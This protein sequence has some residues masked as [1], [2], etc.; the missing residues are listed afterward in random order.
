MSSPIDTSAGVESVDATHYRRTVAI[1]EHRGFIGVS[2]AKSGTALDV[3]IAPS[4]APVIGAVIVRV[5]H[6]FDL[7]ER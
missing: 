7:F 6:L 3:E 2:L 5:K 1:G 4:L